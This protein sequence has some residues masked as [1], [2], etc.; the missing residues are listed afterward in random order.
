MF[1]L[2][3][4]YYLHPLFQFPHASCLWQIQIKANKLFLFVSYQTNQLNEKTHEINKTHLAVNVTIRNKTNRK[5]KTAKSNEIN[6]KYFV[7]LDWVPCRSHSSAQHFIWLIIS[8]KKNTVFMLVLPLSVCCA[9]N[10]AKL[11]KDK[12]STA[13]SKY[14]LGEPW[15]LLAGHIVKVNYHDLF[16]MVVSVIDSNRFDLFVVFRQKHKRSSSNANHFLLRSKQNKQRNI[17]HFIQINYSLTNA[18]GFLISNQLH[19]PPCEGNKTHNNG[20]RIGAVDRNDT[21]RN[22]FDVKKC[23]GR[24]KRWI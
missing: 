19:F 22:R 20:K 13:H 8:I 24:Q 17:F 3:S 15:V 2:I 1:H 6:S 21:E 4:K 23:T 18:N 16:R 11:I 9:V 10:E 12:T 14:R 5:H 7:T